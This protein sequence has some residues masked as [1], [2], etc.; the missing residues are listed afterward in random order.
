MTLNDAKANFK[1]FS[2]IEKHLLDKADKN[3]FKK[4]MKD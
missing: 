3:R 2:I 1:E 4:Y